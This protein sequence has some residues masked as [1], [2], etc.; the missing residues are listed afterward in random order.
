MKNEYRTLNDALN[1]A[2]QGIPVF[3]LARNSTVP[4]KGSHGYH[5][6]TTNQQQ[7]KSW[8]GNENGLNVGMALEPANLLVVDIDR[9]HASGFDGVQAYKQLAERYDKLPTDTYIMKTPRGGSHWFYHYPAGLKIPSKPLC[10]FQPALKEFTGIDIVTYSTPA[11]NTV[12]SN[13]QYQRFTTAVD[14]PI[15]SVT[16][17]Q[18]LLALLT[19][20]KYVKPS[21][22]VI[23]Q[24]TW[25]G[26]LLD[27]VFE[28]NADKGN[29]NVYLTSLCGRLL[30]STAKSSVVYQAL[31]VANDQ[32]P[33][34]LPVNEVNQ[35]FK[36]VLKRELRK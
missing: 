4:L 26:K 6:A 29:R 21:Q 16:C 32:L 8:F 3:P 15:D 2:Q 10:E 9:N 18:W 34:A 13:G 35:I 1:L 14:R 12:T 17:P 31:R 30:R 7:I 11:I 23:K 24:K 36:S 5:D 25:T 27:S 20:Q 22:Q 28:P 33:T 19:A